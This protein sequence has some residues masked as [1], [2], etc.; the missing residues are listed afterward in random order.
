MAG[1]AEQAR[2]AGGGREAWHPRHPCQAGVQPWRCA[3]HATW[4]TRCLLLKRYFFSNFSDGNHAG[5]GRN[6]LRQVKGSK[7]HESTIFQDLRIQEFS[8]VVNLFISTG[9]IIILTTEC[10]KSEEAVARERNKKGRQTR[11]LSAKHPPISPPF[12]HHPIDHDFHKTLNSSQ[13][14]LQL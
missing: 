1:E 7:M 12:R 5:F 9:V 2:R 10:K 4:T 3:Q 8:I 14:H 11:R 13:T 6:I